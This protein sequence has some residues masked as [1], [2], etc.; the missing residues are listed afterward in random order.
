MEYPTLIT[1]GGHW[2]GPP[3]IRFTEMLAVH[4]FGHQHFFG[5]LASNEQ[6]SPFLDEG[7][8]SFAEDGCMAELYG[9]GDTFDSPFLQLGG[10]Q[11]HRARALGPG[12]DHPIA[13]SA[14]SFPT[15]R[16]YSGLVYART[17]TL[18]H[19]LRRVY[20]EEAFDRTLGR[21]TRAY[22]FKHPT[23][24]DLLDAL[25][26]GLGAEAAENARRA[27]FE[28]ATV[29]YAA[30]HLSSVKERSPS[31]VFDRDAGKRETVAGTETGTW[32]ST[33][34]VV[35]RGTLQFPVQIRLRFA[36]GSARTVVWAGRED[37]VR[38]P[39]TSASELVGAEV[40]P[41]QRIV[42]DERR[43]NDAIVAKRTHR[44]AP[45]V[46]ETAAYLLGLGQ[47]GISP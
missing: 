26:Q 41:E 4:E 46:W 36:D 12:A 31:G 20:G 3:A 25:A 23:P 8:N 19:T 35:R 29:D 38:L 42:L 39:I 21:Y 44:V 40:D 10:V 2:S 33:L 43:D 6:R 30:I 34:V 16:H 32:T 37:W 14:P 1:T 47:V 7:L 11:M 15:S 22:R 18:L 28:R 45:R 17:A 9:E 5:L 27:L 24:A 13:G